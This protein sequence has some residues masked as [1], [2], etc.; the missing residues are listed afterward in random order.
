M[1]C[2]MLSDK[3]SLFSENGL[4]I[5]TENEMAKKAPAKGTKEDKKPMKEGKMPPF[6][7]GGKK[8]GGK[9]GSC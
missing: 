3:L 1:L 7:K 5:H 4:A 6:M 8:S 9:K 2:G